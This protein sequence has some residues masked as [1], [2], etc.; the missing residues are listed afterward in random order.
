MAFIK[1][2]DDACIAVSRIRGAIR[3]DEPNAA[4]CRAAVSEAP[5]CAERR[6]RRGIENLTALKR[7]ALTPAR[8]APRSVEPRALASAHRRGRLRVAVGAR[9]P[10]RPWPGASA[11]SR[12]HQRTVAAGRTLTRK[13]P[14][15]PSRT[16]YEPCLWP[17]T[18]PQARAARR[19]CPCCRVPA[20]A[21]G[22]QP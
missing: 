9:R 3:A 12:I 1:R 17:G 5:V 18:R 13:R 21:A 19:A 6:G 20:R 4:D 10:S 2:I 16:A 14:F 11:T 15:T 8:A 22:E 7:R